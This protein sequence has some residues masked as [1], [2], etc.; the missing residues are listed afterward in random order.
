MQKLKLKK[1]IISINN[2]KKKKY[3]LGICVLN[4]GKKI[5]N[6]IKKINKLN[7]HDVDVIICDGNSS[8]NSL[9]FKFLKKNN[10]KTLLIKN[11]KYGHLSYQILLILKYVLDNNYK[12]VVLMDGN[13]KDS[14]VQIPKF[15]KAFKKGY[16]YI[17]GSRYYKGGKDVNTPVARKFLTKYIHPKFFYNNY[18]KFTDTAN[19]YKGISRKF[20]LQNKK[21]IFRN[22]FDYYNLQYYL[23]RLA[24]KKKYKVK[25]IGVVRK[26]KKIHYEIPSHT[27]GV[28]YFRVLKDL[29]L[30]NIGY[31]D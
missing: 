6:Q 13:D 20:I 19:G 17:H 31:Y 15:I 2:F 8:D 29:V 28:G 25:E 27:S 14:I 7:F 21:K 18:F 1:K 24:I 5:V 23:T 30:T 22:C 9:N 4:E 3:C 11:T 10:I 16:Y 26:Y 12:G